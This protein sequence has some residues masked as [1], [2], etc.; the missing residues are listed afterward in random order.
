MPVEVPLTN[1][2]VILAIGT[3]AGLADVLGG[4]IVTFRRPTPQTTRFLIALGAGFLLGGAFF[5]ML[6]EAL[7]ATSHAP[8]LIAAGYL[9]LY[10]VEHVF[11]AHSHG[12]HD[13]DCDDEELHHHA[14]TPHHL[15]GRPHGQTPAI[16]WTAGLAALAGLILHTFLDGAAVAIAFLESP[17]LGIIVFLAVVLHKLPEGFSLSAIMLAAGRSPRAALGSTALIGLSTL[18]GTALVLVVG[19]WGDSLPGILLAIATGSFL[20]IGATDMIPA[21][22]GRNKMEL[23]LVL[24]GAGLVYV[25]S[26]WL[27]GLGLG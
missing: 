23:G 12:H 20:Y 26:Q 10:V 25:L 7:E 2:L 27:H 18:A 16:S 1:T 14:H 22:T 24:A 19:E 21:T 13:H 5:D 3:V 17:G 6:P 4:Y 11:T 8:L 9:M 15:V